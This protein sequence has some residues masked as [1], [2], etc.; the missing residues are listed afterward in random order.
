MVRIFVQDNGTGMNREQIDAFNNISDF[1]SGKSQPG[2]NKETGTGL[3]LMLCKTL[4]KQMNGRMSVTSNGVEP[5]T[6]FSLYLPAA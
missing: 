6:T 2:T 4:I 1:Y 3:G 5:G